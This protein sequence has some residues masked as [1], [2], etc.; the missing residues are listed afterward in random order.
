MMAIAPAAPDS[1]NLA[2]PG[3]WL[4]EDQEQQGGS[5]QGLTQV[6]EL[7]SLAVLRPEVEIRLGNLREVGIVCRLLGDYL[8][9]GAL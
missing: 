3:H 9:P 5:H 4:A 7:A 6:P 2:L 1:R 8:S